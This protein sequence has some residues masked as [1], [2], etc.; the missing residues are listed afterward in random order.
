VRWLGKNPAWMQPRPEN[1]PSAARDSVKSLALRLTHS[2]FLLV[3]PILQSRA[4]RRP[5]QALVD[6]RAGVT[7]KKRCE[8][9]FSESL[10][11]VSIA[12]V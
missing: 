2:G 4:T 11:S 5:A 12:G 8:A 10:A 3:P 1:G 9:A 6:P 7:V